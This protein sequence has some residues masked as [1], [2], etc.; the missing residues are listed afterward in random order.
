MDFIGRQTAIGLND[1]FLSAEQ[2]QDR[3]GLGAV[4]LQ[5]LTQSVFVVIAANDELSAADIARF[6]VGRSVMDQVVIKSTVTTEPACE[7]SLE[8][9]FIWD[10]DVDY[11]VDVIALQKELGLRSVPRKAIEDEAEVPIVK[12]Q[13]VANDLL[14]VLIVHHFAVCD[15]PLDARTELRVGLNVPAKDVA[16]RDVNEIKVLLESF[17]LRPF[18]AA[19]RSHDDVLV[20]V[21]LRDGVVRGRNRV[22]GGV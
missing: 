3:F 7:N 19:L 22:S 13:S 5:S 10:V 14:D 21:A 17:R 6:E 9:D 1:E 20:H 4:V 2:F 16:D 15:E 12:R 11:G 18:A 8:D